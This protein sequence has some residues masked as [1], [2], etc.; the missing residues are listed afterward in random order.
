VMAFSVASRTRELGVRS[1]LGATPA[2][3]R[4][5][6]LGQGAWVGG[7]AVAIGL[8]AAW[9]TTRGMASMLYEVKPADPA[10]YGAVAV[11][12][13]LVALF[14]TWL[15]ARTATRVDPINALREP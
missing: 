2:E 8:G 5:L 10:T 14:A 9:L 7:L 15:P 1:A 3:L 12:L 11:V 4:H 13:C 6:V